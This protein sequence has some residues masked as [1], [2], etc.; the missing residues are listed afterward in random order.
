MTAELK[1]GNMFSNLRTR[2]GFFA[3]VAAATLATAYL[4]YSIVPPPKLEFRDR[5]FP[6]GFR[7]LVLESTSS[8]FDPLVSVAQHRNWKRERFVMPCFEI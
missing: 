3:I 1:I 6:P 7:E 2:N 5:S 8:P 4:L